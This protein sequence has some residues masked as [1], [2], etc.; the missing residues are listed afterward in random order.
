MITY[1]C[2]ADN[3]NKSFKYELNITSYNLIIYIF[4]SNYNKQSNC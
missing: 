1:T 2:I 4:K 3:T